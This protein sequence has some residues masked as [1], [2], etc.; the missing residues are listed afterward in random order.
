ML[1]KKSSDLKEILRVNEGK[2]GK[3]QFKERIKFSLR[4]DKLERQIRELIEATNTLRR[5]RKVSTSWYDNS[6]QSSSRTITMFAN[7]LQR[8]QQHANSLHGAIAPRL[9]CGCHHEHGTILYLEGQ[10]AVLEKRYLTI[11]FK[12]AVEALEAGTMEGVRRYE[13][14]IEVLE[15]ET[16]EYD[17]SMLL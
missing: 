10:S 7:F 17:L 3:Y 4:K 16:N 13:T 12:L 8:I 15:N 6:T 9:A 11:N 14:S 1:L 2:E 5:L